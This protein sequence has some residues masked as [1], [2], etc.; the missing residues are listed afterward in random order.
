MI[1][2]LGDYYYTFPEPAPLETCALDYLEERVPDRY[3][4]TA[5]DLETKLTYTYKDAKQSRGGFV[6]TLK[7]ETRTGQ[8]C[9]LSPFVYAPGN[10]RVINTKNGLILPGGC[11]TLKVYAQLLRPYKAEEDYDKEATAP[12]RLPRGSISS[13]TGRPPCRRP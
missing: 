4:L 5:D 9:V 10:C 13:T 3:Y 7:R 8:A 1:S 6:K 12:R 2:L 11:M